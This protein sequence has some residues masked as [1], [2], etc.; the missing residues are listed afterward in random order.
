M[1]C[2]DH[3]DTTMYSKCQPLQLTL[4]ALSG[5]LS[6]TSN[7]TSFFTSATLGP[8]IVADVGAAQHQ[9]TDRSEAAPQN[10]TLRSHH[11]PSYITPHPSLSHIIPHPS[12]LTIALPLQLSP[13]IILSL[14]SSF[15]SHRHPSPLTSLITSH[16]P[17]FPHPSPLTSHSYPLTLHSPTSFTQSTHLPQS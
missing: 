14:L 6:L 12:P 1:S 2:V 17:S 10:L 5:K 15:T 9:R 8:S 13:F 11:S 4:T 16:S 3:S 7:S